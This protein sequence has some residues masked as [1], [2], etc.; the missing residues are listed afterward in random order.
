MIF[1]NLLPLAELLK[2]VFTVAGAI[3]QG[4]TIFVDS[5]FF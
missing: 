2:P 5:D 1:I 3:E 4:N